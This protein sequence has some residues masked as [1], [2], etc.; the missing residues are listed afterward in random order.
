[1]L[2]LLFINY[3]K[4]GVKI[5]VN[6]IEFKCFIFSCNNPILHHLRDLHNDNALCSLQSDCTLWLATRLLNNNWSR[7]GKI[8]FF[9]YKL[10]F[11]QFLVPFHHENPRIYP[12]MLNL[13]KGNL[14]TIYVFFMGANIDLQGWVSEV[15]PRNSELKNNEINSE[16][17]K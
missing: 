8:V 17:R 10:Y 6:F 7:T 5:E 9:L 12:W 14:Q 2:C 11:C 15:F 16:Q 3:G 13:P 4:I 1:M